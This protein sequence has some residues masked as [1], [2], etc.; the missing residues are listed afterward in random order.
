L[1]KIREQTGAVSIE[2]HNRVRT[3]K[4]VKNNAGKGRTYVIYDSW[5]TAANVLS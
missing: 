2:N 5:V 3:K 4:P 1:D